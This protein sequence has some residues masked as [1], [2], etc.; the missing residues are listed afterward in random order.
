MQIS[1]RHP[2]ALAQF[3][4]QD[5][6]T[7][8]L[9]QPPFPASARGRIRAFH[10]AIR[11]LRILPPRNLVK[12]NMTSRTARTCNAVAAARRRLDIDT[13]SLS[14]TQVQR[15]PRQRD[16]HAAECATEGLPQLPRGQGRYLIG[17]GFDFPSMMD[18]AAW[19]NHDAQVSNG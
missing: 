16:L 3:R 5:G 14:Q 15:A 2:R 4:D 17:R 1:D 11:R 8:V 13:W 9:M 7:A 6:P 12:R 19:L 10:E 18:L